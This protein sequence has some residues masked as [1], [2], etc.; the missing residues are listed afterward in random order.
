MDTTTLIV[1]VIAVLAVLA[2]AFAVMRVRR[3]KALRE[4]FGPEYERAMVETGAR[5]K[6]EA[7]LAEREKRVKQFE[8]HD[9]PA[10][11]ADRFVHSWK[12]VQARFVDDPATAIRKADDLIGELMAARGYPVSDFEQRAADLSVEHGELVQEYR[13]AHQVAL[14]HERGEAGTEDLRQAMIH[15]RELFADLVGE[16]APSE[17]RVH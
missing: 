17:R 11:E 8:L 3:S 15:Y 10:Q 12:A 13:V 5:T 9:L 14:R 7:E 1:I 16:P 4:R 2:A 6:A